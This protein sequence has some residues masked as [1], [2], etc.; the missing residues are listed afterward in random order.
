[1]DEIFDPRL[2]PPANPL[3]KLGAGQL[4]KMIAQRSVSSAEV[5]EAFLGR[6]AEVDEEVA[7]VCWPLFEEAKAAAKAAD[8]FQVRGKELG[9]LHG[10]PIT[11]KECFDIAGTPSTMGLT[12]RRNKLETND[13]LLVA[14]LKAAGAIVLG[15]TNVPQ[16]MILHET[17]N[18]IYGR[19]NNPRDLKRTPGGSS[20]GEGA[21]I[22][23]CGSP[24]GLG[25]DLGGSIRIP[26]HFCGV[27]GL[28]PSSFRLTQRGTV[29]NMRG[30]E[31]VQFQPGPLARRVEDLD[32]S[33]R[34]MTAGDDWKTNPHVSAAPWP[35]FKLVNITSLR[36]GF[37]NDD[38][39]STPHPAIRRAVDEAAAAVRNAG[40]EVEEIPPPNVEQAMRLYFAVVG[41]DGAADLKRLAQGSE[42]DPRV[43]SILRLGGVS[44][45][46]R[47][48]MAAGLRSRGHSQ[49][50][51]LVA[52]AGPRK[53]DEYWQLTYEMK[54]FVHDYLASLAQRRIDAVICPP[55]AQPA[56]GHGEGKPPSLIAASYAFVMNVLGVPCGVVPTSN[57]RAAEGEQD[58][59]G[60]PVAVQVAAAPWREDV[61]LRV[62]QVLQEQRDKSTSADA[63]NP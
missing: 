44:R 26:A 62:M 53:A 59:L 61:V 56:F 12:A 38:G 7:A 2:A 34:V 3:L 14:R 58:E 46:W 23:A 36:I 27:C 1:M 18:P 15:K 8:E 28:K 45:W 22:A 42:L 11:I 31:S 33:M 63:E 19:T 60:L 43:S 32:R 52:A 55:H 47:P 10:V 4:A 29:E 50:A 54:Q 49:L 39:Y 5:T 57:V 48:S 35:D 25:S 40:A 9:P 41:A 37:F 13:G 51:E 6:I 30:M 20:G 16:L 17:D 24:L 21:I